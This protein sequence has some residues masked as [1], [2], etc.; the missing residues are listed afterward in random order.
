M[1]RNNKKHKIIAFLFAIILIGIGYAYL[2]ANLKITGTTKIG[3]ARFDVHF[4]NASLD[5]VTSN[6][7]FPSNSNSNLAQGIPIIKGE[8][9]TELEWHVILNQPGEGYTAKAVV[10]NSG[11]I[12]AELDFDN[13]TI[14]VKI[15]DADEV[16]STFKN[17]NAEY[18]N[19]LNFQYESN[20][21]ITGI[22][23][24]NGYSDNREYLNA[25]DSIDLYVYGGIDDEYITN[26]EWENI[27]GKDITITIDL[28]YIQGDNNPTLPE[29][30]SN[31]NELTGVRYENPSYVG[32][33]A[34]TT[35]LSESN[36]PT[37]INRNLNYFATKHTMSY[38][39]IFNNPGD[40]Y[41]YNIDLINEAG[42]L[43]VS[44]QYDEIALKIDDDEPITIWDYREMKGQFKDIFEFGAVETNNQ[45]SYYGIV[46][47][48]SKNYNFKFKVKDDIT[49][50]NLNLIK[51]KSLIITHSITYYN[52]NFVAH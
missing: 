25:G 40:Y 46:A 50:E 5:Y 14:K 30:N 38:N 41:E 17:I 16:T 13:S 37:V 39:V 12:D 15:G 49:E 2:T 29:S 35:V 51:G 47:N 48:S 45:S 1:R 6:V 44:G 36:I 42:Y 4:E 11:D 52:D 18:S 27:R 21:F 26:E 24:D 7:S 33:G 9:N 8:N 19:C 20:N 23:L 43:A 28:K 3:D 34:T 32:S 10:V 31:S 22:D